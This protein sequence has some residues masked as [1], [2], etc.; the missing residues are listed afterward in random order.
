MTVRWKIFN[1]WNHIWSGLLHKHWRSSQI[2]T[3]MTWA[4]YFDDNQWPLFPLCLFN[5][6]PSHEFRHQLYF[7]EEI[8]ICSHIPSPCINFDIQHMIAWHINSVST[9]QIQISANYAATD[10]NALAKME[11]RVFSLSKSGG[12]AQ[13]DALL[14]LS[15]VFVAWQCTFLCSAHG[16]LYCASPNRV[17]KTTAKHMVIFPAILWPLKSRLE[18]GRTTVWIQRKIGTG[19]RNS[20]FLLQVATK[21]M[22]DF[23]L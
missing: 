23:K 15:S 10:K 1:V 20:L 17:H 7:S 21:K 12:R 19:V 22:I 14:I 13:A 4:W 8:S 16:T 11:N 6:A 5:I 9:K 2:K 3:K 18:T